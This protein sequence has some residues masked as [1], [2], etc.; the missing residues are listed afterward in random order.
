MTHAFLPAAS[1]ADERLH[2]LERENAKLRRINRVLM[3]RIERDSDTQGGDAYSLFRTAITL[4]AKVGERTAELQQLNR[5]LLREIAERSDTERRLLSAKAEA[6]QAN[7]GKTRFLAAAGHD[8][9]QPLNAARLFLGALAEVVTDEHAR[10]L[11]A[12]ADTALDAMDNLLGTLLDISRLD[13]GAWPVSRVNVP[14]APLLAAIAAEY[15]P[16]AEAVGLELHVVPSGRTVYTDRVLLERALRNLVSNAIR[17]TAHGRVLVGCRR[18]GDAIRLE[19]RDTGVGIPPERRAE[20]F[21][22]F[23]RLGNT[24]RRDDEGLGLGLAIVQRIARLLDLGIELNSEV[25]CGS[26]FTLVV[27]LGHGP[28]AVT[29]PLQ[30]VASGQDGAIAGRCIVVLDNSADV[31]DGMRALLET[32]ECC[33]IT[34][35]T[36]AQALEELDLLL[37]SPDIIVADYHLDDGQTGTAAVAAL[38]S[39]YARAIPALVISSDR[40]HELRSRM[41]AQGFMF[42]PKPTSPSRLRAAIAFALRTAPHGIASPPASPPVLPASAASDPCISASAE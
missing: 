37:R 15:R 27:P 16:Q 8:L 30:A 19:V 5:Q 2:V 21:E 13:A 36:P 10:E 26:L 6:E 7:L 35:L 1:A 22:E 31:L 34:A 12:R 39:H 4:E 41:K 17:Y 33:V 38:R 14:L 9:H 42:L 18:R 25:G 24:P 3:D 20:I 11:L 32:W 28:V 29:A 23:H 40:S